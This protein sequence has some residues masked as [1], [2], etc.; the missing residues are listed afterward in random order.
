MMVDR[1]GRI[2]AAVRRVGADTATPPACLG[3]ALCLLT[4]LVFAVAPEAHAQ[5]PD[6]GHDPTAQP[7]P[8]Y[9]PYADAGH[10]LKGEQDPGAAW[11]TNRRGLGEPHI[12]NAA[13]AWEWGELVYG[14]TYP[15]AL[16]VTNHCETEEAV[17]ITVEGL[18]YLDIPSRVTIPPLASVTVDAAITTPP[19]PEVLITGHETLP[20]GGIFVD[21][22]DARVI[23]WHPWNPPC[24][25]KRERYEV[26]GHIHFPPED[27]AG[28]GDS[29][30]E[31]LAAPDL[32]TVYWNTG[33]R[34]PG[35]EEDCTE[36]MR[37]L[38]VHYRERILASAAREEPAA[39]G[40]LPSAAEIRDMDVES[41]LAFKAR[42][43][44]LLANP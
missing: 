11:D 25:P 12:V 32:C 34:P 21:I 36:R 42:A 40:W 31:D 33:Q 30:P 41:L 14:R 7:P 35:L 5:E 19:P 13:G 8:G 17:T 37:M 26:S 10:P 27:P 15:T 24:G 4:G 1:L 29:G 22:R 3:A 6:P 20:E 23:V 9:D 39:W 18:P 38:A 16:L 28:G 2:R 44:A 43:D